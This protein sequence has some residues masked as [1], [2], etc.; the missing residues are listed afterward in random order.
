VLLLKKKFFFSDQAVDKNDPI[1]LN[2]IYV[3]SRD[4]IV[5]GK[6]PCSQE[7]AVQLAALQV[8]VQHGNHEPDRHKP[9]FINIKDFVPPEYHKDKKEIEKELF[10]HHRRLQGMNELSAKF[11]YVQLC[12]SLKTYGVTFFL[13]KVC[14]T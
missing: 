5:G 8:Q 12:R 9:G 1:Q 10:Q 6:L 2:L 3:Q 11:R 13:V 4:S 7:E 14:S